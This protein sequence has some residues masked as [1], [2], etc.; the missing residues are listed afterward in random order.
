MDA[1][2]HGLA[3]TQA[4]FNAVAEDLQAAMEQTGVGYWTQ[5]RLMAQLLPM[6]RLIVAR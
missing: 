3:V 5:N 1:A 6:R 4:K 2:H